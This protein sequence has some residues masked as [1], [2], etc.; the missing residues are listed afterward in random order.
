[1]AQRQKMA[2]YKSRRVTPEEKPALRTLSRLTRRPRDDG[3]IHVCCLQH[4]KSS[5]VMA[6]RA[7]KYS[8]L[9]HTSVFPA[10]RPTWHLC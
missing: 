5:Y 8:A 6:V 2:I 10:A 7:N 3:D 9:G 4:P 1:M